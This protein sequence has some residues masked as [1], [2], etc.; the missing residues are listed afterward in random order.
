MVALYFV[1]ENI[2]IEMRRRIEEN[3]R[4]E[5]RR[6]QKRTENR[7]EQ[8]SERADKTRHT[9]GRQQDRGEEGRREEKRK[10][11]W[12]QVYLCVCACGVYVCSICVVY[13]MS[14]VCM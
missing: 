7:R 9:T 13:V 12:K 11:V 14:V 2:E 3:R 6:E 10:N 1:L 4:E 5:N 8:I